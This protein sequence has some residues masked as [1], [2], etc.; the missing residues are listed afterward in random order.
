MEQ[1]LKLTVF[2]L[3]LSYVISFSSLTYG[4]QAYENSL[5]EPDVPNYVLTRIAKLEDTQIEIKDLLI[6]IQEFY[7]R[8]L[9]INETASVTYERLIPL[10]DPENGVFD[11]DLTLVIRKFSDGRIEF[12][13]CNWSYIQDFLVVS[14]E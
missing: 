2:L 4:F 1:H 10:Y 3:I 5:K 6:E 8:D 9:V 11:I 14:C 7:N 13:I 12:Q